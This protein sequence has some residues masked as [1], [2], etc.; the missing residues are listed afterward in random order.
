MPNDESLRYPIGVVAERTGLTA[1]VIRVWERR[2]S[3]VEP[4]RTLGGQRTYTLGDIDRL[5]L[6][7]RATM[8]GHGISH[9]ATIDTPGLEELIRDIESADRGFPGAPD[10]AD[11]P[12]AAV[13]QAMSFTETIDPASLEILL[14]RTFARYGIVTFLDL[15]VGPFMRAIGDAWHAG[16]LSMSQEHVAT[17]LVQRVVSQTAPIPAASEGNPTFVA[18]TLEGERHAAGALMAAAI[19]AS[20]GWH[21][22]HLGA[23]LPAGEIA[24]AA[25]QTQARAV[26]VSIVRE[27]KKKK[28]AARLR[29]LEKSMPRDATLLVGGAGARGLSDSLGQTGIVFVESM[30]QLHHELTRIRAR[31]PGADRSRAAGRALVRPRTTAG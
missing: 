3:A 24:G 31:S 12:R 4:T 15:I 23:D 9:I 19:A 2:Y 22:I 20:A 18:A 27:E 26:G 11:E 6:L 16:S 14:R 17:A 1:D 28:F 10:L 29:E 25:L 21:V 30:S 13:E 5:V 7:R 8:S